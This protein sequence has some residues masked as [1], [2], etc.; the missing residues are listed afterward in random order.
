MPLP[1]LTRDEGLALLRKGSPQAAA[2]LEAATAD[3]D[4]AAIEKADDGGK[5]ISDSLM[6]AQRLC[7][8]ADLAE[9]E[10]GQQLRRSLELTALRRASPSAAAAWERGQPS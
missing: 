2:A 4:A 9:R 5:A 8:S 7:K 3:Y 10:R 1:T 6:V